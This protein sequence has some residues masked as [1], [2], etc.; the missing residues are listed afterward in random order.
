MIPPRQPEYLEPFQWAVIRLA[1]YVAGSA[2]QPRLLFGSVSL[3]TEDRPRPESG[4][5]VEQHR[6]GKRKEERVFFRRTVLRAGDAIA[7]YRSA[8]SSAVAT[9]VPSNPQEVDAELDGK[10]ISPSTFV[11][12]P[13]WPTLGV[14]AGPDLLSNPGGPGDPAPF[15][16]SVSGS[17]RIHRRFGDGTG[18]GAVTADTAAI[19]FLKRRLHF[20][21]ADYS[22]YL[23]SLALVVPDPVLRLVQ[24]FFV[25]G[26]DGEP[27]N[28]VYRLVPRAG[29]TT[30][31]LRLTILERRANLLSRFETVLVPRDGLVIVPRMLPVQASGYIVTHPIHG[32]LA[33][34]APLPFIRS[35]QVSFGVVGRR[36][37]VEAPRSDS[38]RSET[39]SYTVAELSHEHPIVVG[40]TMPMSDLARVIAAET[41]RER[42]AEAK[43][44]D[45]TWFDDG[46]RSSALNFVRSRIG[47]ARSY[48]LVADP[49]FG[50][51]QVLQFL[52]AVPRIEVALTILTSRLAFE[53]EESEKAGVKVQNGT[54]AET[55][56]AAPNESRSRKKRDAEV[57]S[58]DGF[59]ATMATFKKR[60]IKNA[61]A[62]VLVG[63]TPPL[64]DRFLVIDGMV[65]FLGNSLNA[66]GERASLILQVPDSEPIVERLRRME[67]QAHPFEEYAERRRKALSALTRP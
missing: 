29:Q 15:V 34:Q 56:P 16:G 18:F 4:Q 43:R 40:E 21:L 31:D 61:S 27:E 48:V 64:H 17:A 13:E 25:P 14:P 63:K 9:P 7:W 37:K 53:S 28:L 5:G 1:T 42:R 6:V 8:S 54:T 46:E 49:Y 10:P 12:D 30:T 19:A 45:Q 59:A 41:R 24:H 20:D 67:A 47:R 55:V 32:V 52:H 57:R 38:P 51:R 39:A 62:F 2:F 50:A 65:W 33:Y 3:L 26:K 44:Y 11:D 58:L 23:G 66:L 36:V 22:E 60:G 35:I